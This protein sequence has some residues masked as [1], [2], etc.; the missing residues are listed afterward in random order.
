M[1]F[2]TLRILA[3][4]FL[5]SLM[6]IPLMANRYDD[7]KDCCASICNTC[8]YECGC[9][10]L[11]CGAWDIEGQVGVAPILWVDRGIVSEAFCG[12]PLLPGANVIFPF[13]NVPKFRTLFGVPWTVGGQIGYALSDNIRVYFEANYVQARA[14]SDVLLTAVGITPPITILFNNNKYRLVDAYVGFRYYWDRW[15]DRVSFFL[16]AK[17]GLTSHRRVNWAPTITVSPAAGVVIPEIP[18]FYANTVASGGLNFG[19]DYCYCG[20]WSFVL[21]GEVVAS[22]GPKSNPNIAFGQPSAGCS[23]L[24]VQG[25]LPAISGINN[26]LIGGIGTELRFPVTLGVRY[27]F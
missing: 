15:C 22:C 20:C 27:S 16:G 8:C 21:T 14:K 5:I 9:N 6:P 23:G 25:A 17:A 12:G 7:G 18:L 3:A 11:Y 13:F 10:P 2:F 19:F 1:K 24:A 26:L 4:L